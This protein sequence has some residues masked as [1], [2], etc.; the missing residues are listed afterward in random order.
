[1]TPKVFSILQL[2]I[3]SFR[4]DPIFT[5]FSQNATGCKPTS[6]ENVSAA[7]C[8]SCRRGHG[9]SGRRITTASLAH[10]WLYSEKRP[11]INRGWGKI[12]FLM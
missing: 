12:L 4:S 3:R 8:V 7:V 11:E 1:M 2:L 10:N 6:E 5:I 9:C